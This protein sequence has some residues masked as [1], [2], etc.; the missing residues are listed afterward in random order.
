MSCT[1]KSQVVG[2]LVK[3]S[4]DGVVR[5]EVRLVWIVEGGEMVKELAFKRNVAVKGTEKSLSDYLQ[6]T[7]GTYCF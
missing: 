4:F 6:N 3:S 5:T 2:H 7:C 1:D